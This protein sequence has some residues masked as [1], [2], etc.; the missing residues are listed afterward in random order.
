[1]IVRKQ[2]ALCDGSQGR[3]I[4]RMIVYHEIKGSRKRI[5]E[6]G[7]AQDFDVSGTGT[8]CGRCRSMQSQCLS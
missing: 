7:W 8:K 5:L 2:L 6:L 3:S 1:M 4:V